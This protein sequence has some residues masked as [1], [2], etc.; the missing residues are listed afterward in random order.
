MRRISAYPL[1]AT[2][3]LTM[4]LTA[5][6]EDE[7]SAPPVSTPAPAPAPSPS[8]S[9]TPSATPAPTAASFNVMPCLGQTHA[10][11]FGRTVA[12][13]VVPD[14][15]RVDLGSP[16]QFPNGRR[17]QDPVIDIELAV[18]FLNLSVH[19]P[20]FLA[21]LPVGPDVNDVP[22]R[23]T[24]PYLAAPQGNPPLSSGVGSNFNFRTD[25]RSAYIRV[26]R[27]GMPAVATALVVGDPD[28]DAF[29]DDN[30]AIDATGK[31]VPEFTTSLQA[32]HAGLADDLTALGAT[33]CST[34]I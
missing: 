34:R 25:A 6:G 18:L 8:P 33:V 19:K 17:L 22:F 21:S 24:F 16:S 15:V 29:N 1:A 13:L 10:D 30:P 26:D 2:L 32:L 28:K 9:P 23:T 7:A 27:M 3:A 31:W 5:C 20:S 4:L 14:L 12:Q 11:L